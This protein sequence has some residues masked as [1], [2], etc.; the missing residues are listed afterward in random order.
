MRSMIVRL[1]WGTTVI[2]V[3]SAIA[4]VLVHA[5]TIPAFAI[6]VAW[7]FLGCGLCLVAFGIGIVRSAR[8]DNI[9][10]SNLFF[11]QGSAPKAIRRQFAIM[12]ALSFAAV[13]VS[14]VRIDIAPYTWLALMTSVGWPGLWAARH[15]V[16]GRRPGFP[17]E[18]A[19]VQ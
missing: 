12:A 8:G 15:G 10:V 5:M 16:F 2:F 6:S 13:L 7:F 18:P 17:E 9:A 3:V 1:A 4:G 11:L 19:P 14:W